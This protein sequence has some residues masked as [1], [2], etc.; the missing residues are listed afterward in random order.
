MPQMGFDMTQGKIVR[1]TRK[2]GDKVARGD[3][4]ADIET[5]KVVLEIEAFSS[6]TLLRILAGEGETVPVG[7]PIALLGE[8][9]EDVSAWKPAAPAAAAEAKEA[10]AQKPSAPEPE[11]RIRVS[12]IARK[13]AEE[14]GVDL[15]QVKG[16]GPG[17]R[18]T[19][20]DVTAHIAAREVAP[21][22]VR[23]AAG[24]VTLSPMRQAVA[25][26]MAQSKREIPHFYLT[27]EID[28]TEAQHLRHNLNETLGDDARITLNDLAIRAAALALQRF[29]QL[30][31]LYLPDGIKRGERINIG[32]A[33]ALEEGLVAPALLD[34]GEKRL[35]QIARES[36]G[37]TER[38][39]AG[40][41]KPEEFAGAT[42]TL[43][44]LGM[45]GVDSFQAIINPPQAAI[46]AL[47][48]VKSKPV[49]KGGEVAVAEMMNATLS[50]DHRVVDGAQG[51]QFMRE[52]KALL[53]APLRLLA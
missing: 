27:V 8:A 17:G 24:A 2:E 22:A 19:K 37:L 30:N 23:P 29:P 43:T 6:G 16:S 5:E 36:K 42:F 9:G 45:L 26:H 10:V 52:F 18:I 49:V 35:P 38:T 28:M 31:S 32:I 50:A 34:C 47:G 25:R 13:L 20:E 41:L 7:Q 15:R 39:K 1:W 51:A 40:V 46:L 33:V 11:E 21:A 44:N 48:S 53:E 14:K 4:I 12:P 3:I